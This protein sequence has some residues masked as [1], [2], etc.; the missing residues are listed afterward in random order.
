M[1]ISLLPNLMQPADKHF[2]LF[3]DHLI[4]GVSQGLLSVACS[5]D[6]RALLDLKDFTG[7]LPPY[8]AV[9]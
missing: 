4:L 3:R 6:H 5:H 9:C 7:L 2:E 1:E 8:R